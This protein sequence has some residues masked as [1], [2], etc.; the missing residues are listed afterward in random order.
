MQQLPMIPTLVVTDNQEF[1]KAARMCGLPDHVPVI[2]KATYEDVRGEVVLG[3]LSHALQRAAKAVI[4]PDVPTTELTTAE[5]IASKIHR[6]QV[7]IS[8]DCAFVLLSF[9]EF[10]MYSHISLYNH[11]TAKAG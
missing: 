11:H 2:P 1:L 6:W 9:G 3:Y 5:E 10:G 7:Y 4:E 8:L